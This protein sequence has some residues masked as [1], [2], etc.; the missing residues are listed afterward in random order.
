GWQTRDKLASTG[1]A[2]TIPEKL[3]K[4]D[5]DLLRQEE[6]WLA[7]GAKIEDDRSAQD[8]KAQLTEATRDIPAMPRAATR[9]VSLADVP[10]DGIP[11]ETS[12]ALRQLLTK[13]AALAGLKS[14]DP[15]QGD[16]TKAR[17]EFLGKARAKPDAAVALIW[18]EV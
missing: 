4:L 2:R 17:E 5:A 8:L 13:H 11:P 1:A 7:R 10:R 14:E 6:L 15:A 16:F 18:D 12:T 9:G 3:R